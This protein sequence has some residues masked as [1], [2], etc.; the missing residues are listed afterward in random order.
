METWPQA[1]QPPLAGVSASAL[2]GATPTQSWKRPRRTLVIPASA[3]IL[4]KQ[5]VSAKHARVLLFPFSAR[6]E[7]AL[8]ELARRYVEYLGDSVSGTVRVPHTDGTR[9][10]PDTLPPGATYVTRPPRRTMTTAASAF[11]AKTPAERG[12]FSAP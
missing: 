10:V 12:S 9:S 2:A 8:R 7:T 1:A 5:R 3:G 4:T 6:T 11:L